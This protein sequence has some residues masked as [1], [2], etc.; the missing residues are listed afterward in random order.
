MNY[1][2]ML[3]DAIKKN[4]ISLTQLC[5]RLA[6]REIWVDRAVLSKIQNGKLPPAKDEVNAVLAEILNIDPIKF[7]IAAVKETIPSDLFELIKKVD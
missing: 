1:A 5:F 6:Q 4:S 3:R 7:R 2:T